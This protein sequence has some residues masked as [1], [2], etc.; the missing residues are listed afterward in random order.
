MPSTLMSVSG[1]LTYTL[2]QQ[3][4]H[5]ARVL[6]AILVRVEGLAHDERRR[7]ELERDAALDELRDDALLHEE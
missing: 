4:L 7:R 1:D 3:V 6:A 2:R 5:R